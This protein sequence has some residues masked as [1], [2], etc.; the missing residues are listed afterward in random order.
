MCFI[1]CLKK[2]IIM[3]FTVYCYCDTILI[4]E[5]EKVSRLSILSVERQKGLST[6]HLHIQL[7]PFAFELM[8][9]AVEV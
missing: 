7:D 3:Y 9:P 5:S 2:N 6:S 8:I 4:R 1:R